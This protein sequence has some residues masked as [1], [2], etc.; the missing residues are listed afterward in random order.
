MLYI[1]RFVCF[2]ALKLK[3]ISASVALLS[4]SLSLSPR[5]S[6]FPPL[7]LLSSP[8]AFPLSSSLLPNSLLLYASF[9]LFIPLASPLLSS[10][11]LFSVFPSAYL[12]SLPLTRLLSPFPRFFSSFILECGSYTFSHQFK[13][14]LVPRSAL[15]YG[16]WMT[17]PPL[18]SQKHH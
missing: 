11:V 2:A 10:R 8:S 15:K 3:C 6:F 9:I 16:S 5:S 17:I 4:S 1:S 12:L 13:F 14:F 7:F 18:F